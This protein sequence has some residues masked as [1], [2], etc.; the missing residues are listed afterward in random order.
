MKKL[1]AVVSALLFAGSA[2]A[3][4]AVP[5]LTA[6]KIKNSKLVQGPVVTNIDGTKVS[7]PQGQS[8]IVGKRDNGSIVVRGLNLNNVKINDASV[9]T[10]GY[11][12]MS[13]QPGSQVAF[14][15]KGEAL[16]ITDAAGRSSTVGQGGAVS[17]KNAE[18][19]SNT[20]AEMK[21]MAKE[22]A[23]AA[24]EEGIISEEDVLPAFVA[25]TETS[26]TA[27]EQAVQNVEDT[28][29]PSAPRN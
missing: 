9:Y 24:V 18:V 12:I 16:T 4:A 10:K 6:T 29:S 15:N 20:A 1:I 26:A 27:V 2:F 11:T 17:A 28:L 21:E 25:A 5:S 7:V 13:Y 14:L 8:V 23:K 19:N 3:V 22:E